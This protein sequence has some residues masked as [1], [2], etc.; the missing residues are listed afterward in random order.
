[1][2]LVHLGLDLRGQRLEVGH[3]CLRVVVED[4]ARVEQPVRGRSAA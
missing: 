2:Q 3:V 4:H 1:M